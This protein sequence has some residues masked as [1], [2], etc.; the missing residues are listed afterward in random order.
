MITE[1]RNVGNAAINSLRQWKG[2]DSWLDQFEEGI[3]ETIF[4]ELGSTSIEAVNNFGVMEEKAQ[5]KYRDSQRRYL[6]DN[7]RSDKPESFV[8]FLTDGVDIKIGRSARPNSRLSDLQIGHPAKLT[9]LG[10]MPGGTAL[11]G[12]LHTLFDASKIRGEWYKDS[13]KLREFIEQ[14]CLTLN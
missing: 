1:I 2:F 9:L 12:A 13:P 5:A 10:T 4:Y 8:Y 11:E 14:N 6:L 3:Q 7:K